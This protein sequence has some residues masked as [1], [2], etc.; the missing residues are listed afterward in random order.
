MKFVMVMIICFGADCEAV[1][2]KVSTFTS[3]DSC[4]ST[5]MQTAQYMK[6]M[7]PQ[8][9][10]DVHCRDEEQIR[11]FEKFIKNGGTPTLEQQ[12]PE[13]SGIEA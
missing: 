7:F 6:N 12:L 11:T 5:A 8:S 3:Y 10:R 13:K 2:D 4:Y 9:A 1:F